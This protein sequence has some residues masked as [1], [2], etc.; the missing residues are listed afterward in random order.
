MLLLKVEFSKS[1]KIGKRRFVPGL[2]IFLSMLYDF[3]QGWRH[4]YERETESF[5]L[6]SGIATHVPGSE[7]EEG[8]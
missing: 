1:R 7:A 2:R 3:G 8:F 6:Y 5:P 4:E